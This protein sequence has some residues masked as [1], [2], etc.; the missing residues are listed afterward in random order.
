MS[1]TYSTL[2]WMMLSVTQTAPHRMTKWKQIH[3]KETVAGKS[4]YYPSHFMEERRYPW[5]T[6]V[7]VS[8]L[9]KIWNEHPFNTSHK[10][11]HLS[12]PAW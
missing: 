1:F 6:S 7:R 8:T 5:N 12:Q 11:V 9:D 4:W 10:H 3:S 2:Y